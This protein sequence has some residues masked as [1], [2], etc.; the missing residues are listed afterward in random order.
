MTKQTQLTI[1]VGGYIVA[2]PLGGMTWHHLNYLLGLH[3]LGHEV[4]F[5]E[6]SGSYSFP[7]NPVTWQTSADSTYGRKYLEETFERYGLPKRYCY[8]SEFEDAYYGLNREELNSLLRRADLLL[9]VSGV[10]PMREGRARARRCAVIDTDPVFTQLR[11]I[12][13][14]EFANY[15]R[16]F[17]A[18]ATFGRL[19]GTAPCPLPTHGFDWIGT[20]QP[21]ALRHWPVRTESGKTFTTIGKWEHTSDRNLQFNGK[22]YRSSKGVEWMKMIDLPNKVPWEMTLGMLS[23]PRETADQFSSH[24]WKIVNAEQ[25]TLSC[26]AYGEFLR[27]SAGEFTVAKEIYSG[28]PSGWFS[29]RSAAYLA[30]G[31]PVV[32][33]ETGFADW[34][35]AGKG[36]FSYKEADEA[37]A[38][39]NVIASDYAG[40]ARAARGIAEQ[41]F[42]SKKVLSELL[43]KVM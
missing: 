4:W 6:D 31:R 33:Q 42:D 23:M 7:Y 25:S 1:V 39:L 3:E 37:A 27:S 35:P 22:S 8:Y 12:D 14:G 36:L 11:M 43:S 15:Y 29:D 28:L 2:Y 32:T 34:L 38:A 40:H 5:L 26:E 41:F 16:Q 9:C 21:I 19:I 13:D 10:T 18:V 30:S 17:D 24:G 20:N